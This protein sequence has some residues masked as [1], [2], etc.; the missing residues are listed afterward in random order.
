M[1]RGRVFLAAVGP[2]MLV[3][4]TGVGAGDLAT[5]ALTGTQ[6]GVTLLWA[7]FVGAAFKLIV[8]EGL[9]RWQLVTGSTLLE[10]CML[11]FGK[12]VHWIFVIYLVIWSYLVG[13]AL[14]SAC[15]ATAHA[16]W[17]LRDAATDKIIYG[18]GHSALAMLLIR[19]GGF[20]LFERLMS[21]SIG[22]MFGV[23]VMTALALQ[24]PWSKVWYSTFVPQI[25]ALP[26]AVAWT[27]ALW[28]G[29][30]G[31]VTVLCYG[32]WIREEGREG[33]QWIG[34]CRLDLAAG[35]LMTAIFGWAM[36]IIGST[37]RV[38]EGSSV[39]IVVQV[40]D[41][42]AATLGSPFRWAFLIGAWTAV[43]SSM[44]G[45][46]Q[47]VPYLFA[48]WCR[49]YRPRAELTADAARQGRVDTRGKPYRIF[50]AA[51]A[52]LPAIGLWTSFR[53]T[54]LLYAVVG[55][56]F[57]PMLALVLL[58]LNGN[59]RWLGEHRNPWWIVALL[60]TALV[61]FAVAGFYEIAGNWS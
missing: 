58:R 18:I 45:V 59:R 11:H 27:V 21:A 15:G 33:P 41:R 24:P 31:T 54:Q 55:A 42:L 47:S 40:A 61:I 25:P 38:E 39:R 20:R 17:P 35:Y 5:G 56:S 37:V 48:D 29:I 53:Q 14:M 23:T 52:C 19:W 28:G 13:A 43:F 50:Q 44:L 36:I 22:I 60:L 8:N 4:A 3:A 6:F 51:L 26:G 16:I 32:Y 30:G 10:G 57:V 46:W 7:V 49:L 34:T 1:Q 9:A 12:T 2:G